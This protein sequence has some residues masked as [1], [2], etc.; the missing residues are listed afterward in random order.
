MAGNT[1]NV[2][3]LNL[4]NVLDDVESPSEFDSPQP[5]LDDDD[6]PPGD[7]SKK[8]TLLP[9]IGGILVAVAIVGVFGW[10][11]L[12][13]Y[14][15]GGSADNDRG[16]FTPV[17]APKPQAFTPEPAVQPQSQQQMAPAAP[18]QAPMQTPAAQDTPVAPAVQP[19]SLGLAQATPPAVTGEKTGPVILTSGASTVERS[20][21]VAAPAAQLPTT[22]PA[23]TASAVHAPEWRDE[24]E[25]INKRIEGLSDALASIK[26]MVEKLRAENKV[27]PSVA[28]KPAAP[29]E[30]RTPVTAASK[31]EKSESA[32]LNGEKS[33]ESAKRDDLQLQAVLQDR[34]WFKLSN[35]ETI[36]VTLGEPVKGL[37]VVKQIDADDGRVVFSNGAVYR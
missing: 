28:A 31:P 14:F 25:R 2:H 32:K 37:G 36:T 16:A 24:V 9:L 7:K 6:P 34:A 20:M 10:K 33:Q 1:G 21:P 17:N 5:G 3:N 29:A 12:A 18:A 15:S 11:I 26:E 4:D 8:S 30:K 27:R 22:A 35:G 23:V 19:A 13:P